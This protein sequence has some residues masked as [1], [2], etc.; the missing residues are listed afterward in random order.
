MFEITADLDTPVSV[1][2]KLR[3]LRPYYLLESVEGG[4]TQGR[5]SFLGF[6]EARETILY[7]R[8]NA[9]LRKA[10]AMAPRWSNHS[11]NGTYAPFPGGLVGYTGY[12]YADGQA[13]GTL[14]LAGYVATSSVLVFD[15]VRRSITLLHHGSQTEATRVRDDVLT[16][17]RRS[18]PPTDPLISSEPQPNIT[19]DAYSTLVT[20]AQRH[21]SAGE[22]EQLGLS[23][24]FTGEATG[25][26]F[27]VYRALRTLN[28][29]PYLYYI[30]LAGVQIVGSSPQALIRVNERKVSLRPIAG[31]RPRGKTLAEDVQ[32]EAELLADAKEA[33]EHDMLV[34][35]ARQA[36]KNVAESDTIKVH[37]YRTIERHSHVMHMVS[38]VEGDLAPSYDAID[39]L[40]AVFPAGTTVGAPKTTA[41]A[42]L[43]QLEPCPREIY[44][45][46]VGLIGHNDHM[47]Q[48]I[49]I[50]TMWFHEGTYRY[51]AG[52][53]IVASSSSKAEYEECH[54]KGRVLKEALR[55]AKCFGNELLQ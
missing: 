50:R 43:K 44:A 2:M 33:A 31:T 42:L 6:G 18:P 34:E 39:A 1:F 22:L 24:T 55:Q 36:L 5:Y 23:V 40:Q 46:T 38:G 14:P 45:G 9:A 10:L 15:N 28:P 51:Q 27:T 54:A 20:Q 41:R 26:P 35:V 19:A 7:E 12:D 29:S 11:S 48:A 32:L 13:T 25:D 37:P 3:P 52:A 4:V 47:D 49:A 16:A 21:I 53:G 30:D 8:D 17:L